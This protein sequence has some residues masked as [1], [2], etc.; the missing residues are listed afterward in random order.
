MQMKKIM[1]TSCLTH[2]QLIDEK[3][4]EILVNSK[5]VGLITLLMDL[6]MSITK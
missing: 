3:L 2:G 4:A 1:E 5:L 6:K